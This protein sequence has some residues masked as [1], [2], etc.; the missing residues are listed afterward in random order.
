MNSKEQVLSANTW[1]LKKW[2]LPFFSLLRGLSIQEAKLAEEEESSGFHL[3]LNLFGIFDSISEF[4]DPLS[5]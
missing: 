3:F 1:P 4:I 2:V 5:L